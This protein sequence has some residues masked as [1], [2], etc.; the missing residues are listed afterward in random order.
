V[1]A[2]LVMILMMSG[3]MIQLIVVAAVESRK[4]ATIMKKVRAAV[5]T[6]ASSCSASW[7]LQDRPVLPV[8]CHTVVVTERWHICVH[9]DTDFLT[10]RGS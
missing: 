6:N 4:V 10:S 8:S 1:T 5:V 3:K 7:P 9:N 2:K